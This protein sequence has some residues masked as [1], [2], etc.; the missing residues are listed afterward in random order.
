VR[1][2]VWLLM[3]ACGGGSAGPPTDKGSDPTDTGLPTTETYVS[4]TDTG[5][6]PW[7]VSGEE[8][9][10]VTV[11]RGFAPGLPRGFDVHATFAESLPGYDDLA[12]C[13]GGG[14]CAD[15]RP[16]GLDTYVDLPVSPDTSE[17]SFS[18]VG[19]EIEVD[20]L[21]LWFDNQPDQ[22]FAWYTH[23][24]ANKP[25]EAPLVVALPDNGEW[26]SFS[27]AV[28]PLAPAIQA[29]LPEPGT[30]VDLSRGSL[31]FAW[32]PGGEGAVYLSILGERAEGDP[33]SVLYSLEDDGEF[34]LSLD[35]HG[36]NRESDVRFSL[37]RRVTEDADLNGNTLHMTGI[38]EQ[39]Y[40]PECMPYPDTFIPAA[41]PPSGSEIN[42]YYI[43]IKAYGIFADGA[44]HD[45]T[46][47]GEEEPTSARVVFTFLDLYG[48]PICRVLYDISGSASR[49]VEPWP[50]YGGLGV[51][52]DAYLFSLEDGRS[53]CDPVSAVTFGSTDLRD[54]LDLFQWGI[55]IGDNF[56][57]TGQMTY[58]G[59]FTFDGI[60]GIEMDEVHAYEL[61]DCDLAVKS[62]GMRP[63]DPNSGA[64]EAAYMEFEPYYILQIQ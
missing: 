18:W 56:D 52:W 20:R 16:S 22:D 35:E 63:Y 32:S 43:D 3:G 38:D 28:A 2:S 1:W 5:P 12:W 19:D 14:P 61:V 53:N 27:E 45:Y 10:L 31:D 54:W 6:N 57:V 21:D 24:V 40:R 62:A 60:E 36:I 59:Y 4:T 49:Q 26:G 29:T 33:I 48:S 44:I 39:S 30:R 13:L 37:G 58:A 47:E 46:E 41:L 9:S 15:V 64:Y 25:D 50:R 17:V 34:R 42:P 51:I 23:T 8:G 55:G 7:Q 11:Y